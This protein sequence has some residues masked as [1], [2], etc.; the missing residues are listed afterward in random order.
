MPAQKRRRRHEEHLPRRPRP[1]PRQRRRQG[2]VC[3]TQ[4][5]GAPDG[6]G[7]RPDAGA[8]GSPAPCSGHHAS[9]GAKVDHEN[10]PGRRSALP[11]DRQADQPRTERRPPTP[12]PTH[13][14]SPKG[15]RTEAT[16]AVSSRAPRRET[17]SSGTTQPSST[18]RTLR[19]GLSSGFRVRSM[20]CRSSKDRFPRANE[21]FVR[22]PVD[23][24][25][26]LETR[27]AVD[28]A[29]FTLRE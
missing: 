27:S 20:G 10:L 8:R 23:L 12:H 1:Q 28:V 5:G 13:A 15:V 11:P 6:V 7:H 22:S 18:K 3:I 26:R 14:R 29:C 9:A 17:A 2:T 24:G 4:I 25:N 21:R 16:K 19:P